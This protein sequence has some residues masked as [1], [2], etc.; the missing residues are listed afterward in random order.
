MKQHELS[1]NWPAMVEADYLALVDSID[2][3]GVLNA[4]TIFEGQVIDGWNRY[5]AAQSLGVDCPMVDLDPS[6]DPVA[7]VRAQNDK[8][9]HLTP[10]QRAAAVVKCSTWSPAHR[11]NKVEAASTLSKTNKELA[12]EAGTTTRT[13]SDAKTAQKGGLI[14]AVRDGKMTAEAAAKAARGTPAK[15]RAAEPSKP[16]KPEAPQAPSVTPEEES[17]VQI[18]SEENDRLNDRLAVVAMDANPEERA[19]AETTIAD[20]RALIKTMTVELSAVKSSRDS[21]MAENNELKKQLAS[22]RKQL[23]KLKAPA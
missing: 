3:L 15:K 10:S 9:R 18:L 16:S 7:F 12:K 13:I 20:L 11:P 17:A 23:A 1:A 22:Q 8:R 6:I 14:D 21:L 2:D 5:R 4:V 19:A